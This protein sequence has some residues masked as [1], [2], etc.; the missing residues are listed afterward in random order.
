MTVAPP[1][2]VQQVGEPLP[3]LMALESAVRNY[4]KEVVAS[5]LLE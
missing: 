4:T 5:Q 1:R 2:A 3:P